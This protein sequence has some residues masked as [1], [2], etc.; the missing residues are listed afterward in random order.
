MAGLRITEVSLFPYPVMAVPVA[1]RYFGQ[2]G[3]ARR[4]LEGGGSWR[5]VLVALEYSNVPDEWV[6]SCP[7]AV[8][9]VCRF[10]VI[11]Y[12]LMPESLVD[13]LDYVLQTHF[14]VLKSFFN[15]LQ[16]LNDRF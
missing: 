10:I 11:N 9:A 12:L 5:T 4:L 2:A 6:F 16:T 13:A 8:I 3:I 7:A 14:S 15:S 1:V